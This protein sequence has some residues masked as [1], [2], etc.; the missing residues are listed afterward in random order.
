MNQ[1]NGLQTKFDTHKC[2]TEYS[3]YNLFSLVITRNY[4]NHISI[5]K[6]WSIHT[7]VLVYAH[8]LT[9]L[10]E[11]GNIVFSIERRFLYFLQYSCTMIPAF[12]WNLWRVT[13]GRQSLTTRHRILKLQHFHI[14][15]VPSRSESTRLA[16]TSSP[17]KP[18]N[19]AAN[20]LLRNYKSAL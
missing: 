20:S 9:C 14:C 16:S 5:L 6:H 10:G 3:I 8:F 11:N 18:D 17:N 19:Q 13:L 4:Q 15:T 1:G 12:S 2:K 7:V